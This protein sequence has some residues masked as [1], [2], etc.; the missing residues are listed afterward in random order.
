MS[1]LKL[2]IPPDTQNG[3]VFLQALS[4][5]IYVD[6][7][8]GTFDCNSAH[9]GIKVRPCTTG[10]I[11]TLQLLPGQ[12]FY[13]GKTTLSLVPQEYGDLPID[14][15]SLPDSDFEHYHHQGSQ[16]GTPQTGRLG[17]T[18]M[19]TPMLHRDHESKHFTPNLE[20]LTGQ[21]TSEMEDSKHWP[22]NA[23]KL[24]TMQTVRGASDDGRSNSQPEVRRSEYVANAA[25]DEPDPSSPQ[26]PV[27]NEDKDMANA[28]AVRLLEQK[29]IGLEDVEMAG[30]DTESE[31]VEK[32][33]PS[34]SI[35][36]RVHLDGENGRSSRSL[37]LEKSKQLSSPLVRAGT[38]PGQPDSCEGLVP[39]LPGALTDSPTLTT[40]KPWSLSPTRVESERGAALEQS[41]IS[42]FGPQSDGDN[43]V[44]KKVKIAAVPNEDLIEESQNCL[45][46]EV[47]SVQIRKPTKTDRPISADQTPSTFAAPSTNNKCPSSSATQTKQRSSTAT[48]RS[49]YLNSA[50]TSDSRHHSAT[51]RPSDFSFNTTGSNPQTNWTTTSTTPSI[52]ASP[53]SSMRSTR[54]AAR[55]EHDCLSSSSTGMRIVFASSSSAGNSKPFLK[56]LSK[57][58]VKVVQS[59]HDCTVLCVGKEL[60]KTSKLILAVVLGK[61]IIKDNWVTDSVKGDDLLSLVP[62]VRISELQNFLFWAM[63]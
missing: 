19:E 57:K 35:K 11:S 24:E 55:D 14:S 51:E 37:I 26:L 34:S 20:Q 15:S 38:L 9:G 21:A 18:V 41:D 10:T 8:G 12:S 17:S 63:S 39:Q 61:D 36:T 53:H 44:R 45:Q 2:T 42:P 7:L 1:T 40:S 29:V 13:L 3:F 56:F 49:K 16:I 46:R 23:S 54:S 59:V 47:V 33:E 52:S 27:E 6:S 25:T 62:Y 50:V 30:A 22:G 4:S 5:D 31:I 48:K 58:G 43:P 28:T 60:K 32:L